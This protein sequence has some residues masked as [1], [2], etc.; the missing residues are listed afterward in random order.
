MMT[1]SGSNAGR[2]P[3]SVSIVLPR[4]TPSS[5]ATVPSAVATGAIWASNRPSSWARAA[6]SCEASENSSSRVR[7]SLH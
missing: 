4:R 2:R 3:A 6:F 1:P 5:L 7:D